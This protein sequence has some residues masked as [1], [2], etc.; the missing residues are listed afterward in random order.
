MP[1]D[2]DQNRAKGSSS[3]RKPTRS[4]REMLRAL[5]LPISEAPANDNERGLLW[6]AHAFLA[7]HLNWLLPTAA[8]AALSFI[9]LNLNR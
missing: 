7:R 4:H 3:E 6:I 1:V 2:R 5:W 9:L 8:L